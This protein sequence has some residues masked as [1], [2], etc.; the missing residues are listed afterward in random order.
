MW[1]PQ[2]RCVE[3]LPATLWVPYFTVYALVYRAIV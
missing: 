3:P 2:I 1:F